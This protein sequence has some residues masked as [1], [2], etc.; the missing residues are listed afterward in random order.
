MAKLIDEIT[1]LAEEYKTIPLLSRTHGQPASPST[2]G[3]EMANVVY[4]LKR[5]FKQLQN[6]E[7]LGKI[8]GAVGNYNA[9]LSAYPNIDWHKFSEE[10]VTSLGIQW[11]PY[12]TQIEPH[13]YITEFFDAVVRFNTIIIDF[14]RDLWGYIALNHFKQRTIAGEI[15]SSTM[16]HKVNPIDFENSEGNLGLAN[17]VMTHLGQNYQFLAG[18]VT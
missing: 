8:N 18:S 1:R 15:G 17:A 5:Q 13:D 4:R 6:A 14:D 16:P 7:I 12:T 3:K 10:F 9:H 2:V 11:N